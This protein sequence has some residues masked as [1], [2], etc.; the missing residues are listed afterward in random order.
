MK[1]VVATHS[2]RLPGS[3]SIL[4]MSSR[5]SRSRSIRS[6]NSGDMIIFQSRGSP[7]LC[8]RSRTSAGA[9]PSPWLPYAPTS[10]PSL[11]LSRAMYRPCARHCP[12]ILFGE[13][14]MRTAHRWLNTRRPPPDPLRDRWPC[15]RRVLLAYRRTVFIAGDQANASPC[16]DVLGRRGRIRNSRSC[17]V[18]VATA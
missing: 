8:Q 2:R 16:R 13:Y 11:T 1:C 5:V 17:S 6:P 14:I 9:T 7:A 10:R 4:P 15:C 3:F 12:V 18:F